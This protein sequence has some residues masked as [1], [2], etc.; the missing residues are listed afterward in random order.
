MASFS[1]L[2]FTFTSGG[3]Q[4]PSFDGVNFNWGEATHS[5]FAN[6]QAAINVMGVYQDTT[7][8]YL[9]ACPKIVVGYTAH[10]IQVLQLPCVYGG[11]RDLG[12]LLTP[13]PP[14]V[15]LPAYI[16]VLE[17]YFDLGAYLKSNIRDTLDLPAS[18]YAIPGIDLPGLIHGWDTKDLGG[19]LYGWAIKNLM[20][21][22][23][24]HPPADLEAIL[25]V[26]EIRDLPASLTGTLFR[27][28]KDLG[29]EFYKI[30]LRGYKDLAA[31]MHG[32]QEVDLPAS[33]YRVF[34]RDL[35]A[36]VRGSFLRNLAASVYGIPPFD[37]PAFLHGFDERF[38]PASLNGV[39]GPYDIQAYLNA[40]SPKDLPASI[41]GY[42]GIQVPF[43]LRAIVSSWYR[44]DL[45]AS[46]GSVT[47]VDLS[48]YLVTSGQSLDLPASII[49]K[50]MWLKK[51][52]KVSLMEHSDLKALVNF[53]CFSS[54]Y[55]DLPGYLYTIYK[56][57]LRG[58][59]IGWIGNTADNI[60]DLGAYIN[61]GAINVQDIYTVRLVP[62]PE[63]YT[64]FKLT[65]SVLDKYKTYDTLRMIFSSYY[66]ADLP[67]SI[68]GTLKYLDLA[69]TLTPNIQPN[70]TEL[71]PFI[72][73][74]THEVVIDF[75]QRWQENWRRFVEIM[76]NRGGAEPYHYFYVSGEN[77]VYKIDRSRHWTIWVKSY[78]RDEE[79]MIDRHK[80]RKKYIFKLDQY[81]TFDEALRGVVDRAVLP[82]QKDLEA[83]ISGVI[84]LHRDL[85]AILVPRIRHTWS[86]NLGAYLN[87]LVFPIYS[88]SRDLG[89]SLS[90]SGY[91]APLGDTIIFNYLSSE[92]GYISPTSSGV[93]FDWE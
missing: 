47:P 49:P 54:T 69:A 24:A 18:T 66:G 5:A 78:L 26:I 25:N 21:S 87:V 73:P 19:S 22:L 53:Q 67:A 37:L 28:Q 60:K 64:Q 83:R 46:I 45:P 88:D 35:P 11:I 41:W 1:N 12:A 9:K 17:N 82:R 65:F 39:Y 92:S 59:I 44:Y 57:D 71:P 3:Y 93:E 79:T 27:G 42:G 85:N 6:L 40:I 23:G 15:D 8:T 13:A 34:F 10:G 62:E 89:A 56:L 48:A 52:L 63:K 80:V 29:A 32:W 30:W 31:S 90:V 81:S 70:Y 38:L 36:V 72:N 14:H 74:K 4:K 51:V 77:K 33:I 86:K 16:V 7:Y 91:T 68:N 75:N 55:S 2:P 43:D 50:V 20:A 61:A 76:F 58:Y 84:G